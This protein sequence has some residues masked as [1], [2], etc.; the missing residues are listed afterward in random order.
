MMINHLLKHR[1]T[2]MSFVSILAIVV[3]DPQHIDEKLL[4]FSKNFN[5]EKKQI[6]KQFVQQNMAINRDVSKI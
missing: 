6:V 4:F 5:Q 1:K 3:S 2:L